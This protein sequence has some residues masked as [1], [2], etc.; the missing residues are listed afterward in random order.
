[1]GTQY[2]T[3]GVGQSYI[4]SRVFEDA[5]NNPFA[6]ILEDLDPLVLTPPRVHRAGRLRAQG[7]AEAQE[8]PKID[9]CMAV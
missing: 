5:D 7:H 4:M 6:A 8:M 3:S 1:M 2:T 9:F